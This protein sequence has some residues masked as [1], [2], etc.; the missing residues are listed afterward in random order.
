[1]PP[2]CT[3]RT[4]I[5]FG[6]HNTVKIA[7]YWGYGKFDYNTAIKRHKP[8]ILLLGEDSPLDVIAMSQTK[9]LKERNL[10]AAMLGRGKRCGTE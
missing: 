2:I 6:F 3:T 4:R 5:I 1:M 10:R 9:W 8:K 7:A